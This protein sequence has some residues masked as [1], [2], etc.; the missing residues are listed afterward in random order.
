MKIL[1]KSFIED[2]FFTL[3]DPL[4]FEVNGTRIIYR[5]F[6]SHFDIKFVT[7]FFYYYYYYLQLDQKSQESLEIYYTILFK[8]VC[9]F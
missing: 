5:I 6:T 7:P 1:T 8:A 9:P 2:F 3:E 4:P